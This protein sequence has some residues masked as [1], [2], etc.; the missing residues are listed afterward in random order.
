MFKQIILQIMFLI[1]K[2]RENEYMITGASLRNKS[3]NSI[4]M[5]ID[6]NFQSPNLWQ[7]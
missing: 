3:Y 7:R 1:Y 6:K 2:V 5:D 4:N